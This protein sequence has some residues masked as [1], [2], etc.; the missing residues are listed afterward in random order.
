MNKALCVFV[1]ASLS[2]GGETSRKEN[3][4]YQNVQR[5]ETSRW[6]TDKVAKHPVTSVTTSVWPQD[7][8]RTP[9]DRWHDW[10]AVTLMW[11]HFGVEPIPNVDLSLFHLLRGHFTTFSSISCY[12]NP[13]FFSVE[14]HRSQLSQFYRWRE[15]LT[16]QNIPVKNLTNRK[17]FCIDYF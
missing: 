15:N 17:L 2:Y 5:C 16:K 9:V 8:S 12:S 1:L 6:R 7:N 11:L 4:R 3:V 10:Q 13:C 14:T